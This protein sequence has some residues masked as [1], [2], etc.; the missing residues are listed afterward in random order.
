MDTEMYA[1][2]RLAFAVIWVLICLVISSG[3]RDDLGLMRV[4]E[5]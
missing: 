5:V 2:S 1:N 4:L 3:P